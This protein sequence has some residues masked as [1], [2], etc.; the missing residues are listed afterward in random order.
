MFS[1]K[2]G[3]FKWVLG[4]ESYPYALCLGVTFQGQNLVHIVYSSQLTC[5]TGEINITVHLGHV[6]FSFSAFSPCTRSKLTIEKGP[7]I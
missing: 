4:H 3:V 7:I 6:L 5:E 2:F 1:N